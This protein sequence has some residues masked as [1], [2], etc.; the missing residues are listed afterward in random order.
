M[1]NNV[2]QQS[3]WNAPLSSGARACARQSLFCF[4]LFFLIIHHG[5]WWLSRSFAPARWG[6]GSSAGTPPAFPRTPLGESSAFALRG[7]AVGGSASRPRRLGM[8]S[9]RRRT[10]A[11]QRAG[12]QHGR[13]R[14][15]RLDR[16]AVFDQDGSASH[17]FAQGSAAST[18]RLAKVREV[19]PRRATPPWELAPRP[20]CC[21][22]LHLPLQ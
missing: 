19:G 18:W 13:H 10:Y 2:A 12:L 22:L 11:T 7:C 15:V 1:L 21:G 4:G 17:P 8:R 9:I 3:Q 14:L 20:A 6:W 16:G 5:W